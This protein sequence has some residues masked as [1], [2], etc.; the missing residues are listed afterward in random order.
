MDTG[1]DSNKSTLLNRVN[2]MRYS[3]YG[4][5]IYNQ[6]F[7][8]AT[9]VPNSLFLLSK[10]QGVKKSGVFQASFYLKNN[11]LWGI[12]FMTKISGILCSS[13]RNFQNLRDK[14][15]G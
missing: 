2:T 11:I 7:V 5:S 4:Y 6:C 9:D 10:I 8:I 15:Q 12:L 13:K 3:K 14:K 1:G